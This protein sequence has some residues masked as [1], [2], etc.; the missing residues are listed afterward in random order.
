MTAPSPTFERI[1]VLFFLLVLGK[2]FLFDPL[3]QTSYW[4]L[5]DGVM[6]QA[7]I[8]EPNGSR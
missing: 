8:D 4:I 5:K 3:N 2:P 1:A 7:S 6:S